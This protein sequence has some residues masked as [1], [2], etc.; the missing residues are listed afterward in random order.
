MAKLLQTLGAVLLSL[1]LGAAAAQTGP[2]A[3]FQLT[4]MD[5]KRL[6][7]SDFRG[8]WVLVK[9]WAPWCPLCFTDVD[10][11]NDL[12]TRQDVVVIGMAMDYGS[13]PDTVG[14]AVRRHGMRYHA[15]V[16]GGR[17]MDDAGPSRQ[18]GRALVYPTAFLFAPD[19]SRAATLVGPA[20]AA[21]LIARLRDEYGRTLAKT[22][23]RP[24]G[25]PG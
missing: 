12:N 24:R 25:N 4:A 2:A 13:D 15:Q 9:F 16:L 22:P 21:G 8:Q 6:R 1:A 7:L 23:F 11:L 14:A 20:D 17:G 3:D 18:V 19:G 5:G 10:A